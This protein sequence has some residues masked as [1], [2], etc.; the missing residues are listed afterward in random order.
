MN[1]KKA[2]FIAAMAMTVLALVLVVERDTFYGL[3]GDKHRYIFKMDSLVNTYEL[4]DCLVEKSGGFSGPSM[5][6]LGRT[7]AYGGPP[8]GD[9]ILISEDESILINLYSGKPTRII[10][11]MKA[12]EDE[13]IV[14][15]VRIC[16]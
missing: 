15:I 6:Y 10:A 1:G 2:F 13:R 12:K 4:A 5:Q 16:A 9:L 3:L 7:I 14:R 8:T 11:Q